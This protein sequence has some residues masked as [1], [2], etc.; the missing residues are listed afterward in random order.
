MYI[1]PPLVPW[2]E[3]A[4]RIKFV[5]RVKPDETHAAIKQR[6]AGAPAAPVA[7][8]RP[9]RAAQEPPLEARKTYEPSSE[10]DD[11]ARQTYEECRKAFN[12]LAA[13][14]SSAQS[15]AADALRRLDKTEQELRRAREQSTGYAA[16]IAAQE[17]EM[18]RVKEGK[19]AV[20]E[21]NTRLSATVSVSGTGGKG[22]DAKLA[23]AHKAV[24]AERDRLKS[25]HRAASEELEQLRSE[26][27]D[28]MEERTKA[29]QYKAFCDDMM[30][31]V[32]K[33]VELCARACEPH[34][35]DTARDMRETGETLRA[36]RQATL[37]V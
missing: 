22:G 37:R 2:G 13:L 31:T 25:A 12:E 10:G 5:N 15:E 36:L 32:D 11:D 23:A 20:E 16:Q 7:Q 9:R 26:H 29:N 8:G 19:R 33:A 28:A 30:Q 27:Q 34:A 18:R 14:H 21:L 6:K 35:P 4:T 17:L 1:N 24:T 3:M